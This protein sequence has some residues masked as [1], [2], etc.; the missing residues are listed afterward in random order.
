MKQKIDDRAVKQKIDDR[1]VK[2]KIDDRAVEICAESALSY[3]RQCTTQEKLTT[4][5]VFWF[6]HSGVT[7]VS[8]ALL[9]WILFGFGV[10]V[11]SH[12]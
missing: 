6:C 3:N 2:Q 10:T 9:R 7:G 8:V 12:A 1:A 4:I 5:S 11:R